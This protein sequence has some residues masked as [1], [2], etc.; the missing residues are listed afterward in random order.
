MTPSHSSHVVQILHL[1]FNAS[2]FRAPFYLTWCTFFLH[3]CIHISFEL[4]LEPAHLKNNPV[5]LK[6]LL[7]RHFSSLEEL[8]TL[9]DSEEILILLSRDFKTKTSTG[10]CLC[11]CSREQL[12]RCL[13]NNKARQHHCSAL[14]TWDFC[15]L[16]KC[17]SQLLFI[18]MNIYV[19]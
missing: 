15:L 11:L 8:F 6:V 2:L 12:D 10:K 16:N 17:S 7:N 9:V 19:S 5:F 1:H 13:E 14:E 4:S 3:S 18:T